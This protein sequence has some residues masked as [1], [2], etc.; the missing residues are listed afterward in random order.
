MFRCLY[1]W[2]N[3]QRGEGHMCCG[4]GFQR[5][6]VCLINYKFINIDSM[7]LQVGRV[8]QNFF[9]GRHSVWQLRC[10]LPHL[11]AASRWLG[12]SPV[13]FPADADPRRAGEGWNS[14]VPATCVRPGWRTG[15]ELNSLQPPLLV[16]GKWTM[17]WE[18]S[19]SFY[20]STL[21]TLP[22]SFR[23]NKYIN[24]YC[25]SLSHDLQWEP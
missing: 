20:R 8:Q 21:S 12:L 25:K 10:S 15:C 2:I 14:W 16:L 19:V 23:E 22:L 18:V 3:N 4:L 7:H 9:R 17:R 5:F 11:H 24:N 13:W 6:S 1:I